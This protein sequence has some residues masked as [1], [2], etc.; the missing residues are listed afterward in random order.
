MMQTILPLSAAAVIG[1]G[2]PAWAEDDWPTWEVVAPSGQP[3]VL[4]ELI[5]EEQPYSGAMVVVVRLL[6]PLMAGTGLEASEIR[7]DMDWACET[8]GLPASANLSTSP[9]QIVVELMA[10]PTTRGQ[11]TPEI[12][13]FFE[14]YR[15]EGPLCIWELF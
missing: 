4:H 15:L 10:A 7:H 12:G 11:A 6:A 8:W 3:I 14:T 5:F 1:L 2:A 9:D 13:Q